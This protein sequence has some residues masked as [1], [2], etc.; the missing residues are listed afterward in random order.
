MNGPQRRLHGRQHDS[1]RER[2]Q[3]EVS[4]LPV[5]QVGIIPMMLPNAAK[6]QSNK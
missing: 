3:A 2:K 6:P 4:G 1:T 5:N